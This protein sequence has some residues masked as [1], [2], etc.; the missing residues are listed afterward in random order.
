MVSTQL[1]VSVA[2]AL[3]RLRTYAFGAD[4]LAVEVADDVVGRKL[5]FETPFGDPG[6][7]S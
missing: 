2:Q 3:V 7:I 4:R 6:R 5:R 1:D